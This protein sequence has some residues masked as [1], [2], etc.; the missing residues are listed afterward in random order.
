MEV[1][2]LIVV[3]LKSELE[4]II[5]G[6][7]LSGLSVQDIDRIISYKDKICGGPWEEMLKTTQDFKKR[8]LEYE[9]VPM[10]RKLEAILTWGDN[11]LQKSMN[12]FKKNIIALTKA[13]TGSV[14]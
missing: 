2:E 5:T 1:I 6:G 3:T 8:Y 10:E 14:S 11:E 4:G 7:D 13:V 9:S 12:D